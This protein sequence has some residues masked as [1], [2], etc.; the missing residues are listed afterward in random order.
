MRQVSKERRSLILSIGVTLAVAGLIIWF[1]SQTAA[2]SDGLS[3]GLAQRLL[4]LF[5]IEASKR[6]LKKLN[7]FLRKLAHF[8]L[9][10][11][12]GCGLTGIT[13]YKRRRIL[14]A[15]FAAI[16]LG[17][18]FA[19]SDEFHQI[20]SEGRGPTVRDVLLDAC[21]VAAGSMIHAFFKY[22]LVRKVNNPGDRI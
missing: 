4:E 20:F 17:S 10:L 2:E 11:I 21:G 1:S 3:R 7:Q 19:A 18:M 14:M 13:S 6:E 16:V 5:S 12:L 15:V 9:Y 8:I 22:R